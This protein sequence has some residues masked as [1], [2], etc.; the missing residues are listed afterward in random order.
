MR[1]FVEAAIKRQTDRVFKSGSDT[2]KG[3]T[4]LLVEDFT[5]ETDKEESQMSTEAVLARLDGIVGLHNVKEMVHSLHAQ[6]ALAKERKDAGLA[7]QG[8]ATLHMIFAGTASDSSAFS[9]LL[10]LLLLLLFLRLVFFFFFCFFSSAAASSN[11]TTTTT[12]TT[13]QATP[14]QGKPPSRASS[15]T[16]S[17]PSASS[18]AAT[19]SRLTGPAS[20]PATA[21]RRPSRHGLWWRAPW[22]ACFSWTRPTPW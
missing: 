17:P 16:C 6:L 22:G 11:T 2:V 18:A 10:L 1:T 15:P 21:A 19:S 12:T 9:R 4:T 7:T 20:L 5:G 3:L 14:A 8:S 13:S